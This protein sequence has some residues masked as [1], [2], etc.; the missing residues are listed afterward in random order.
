MARLQMRLLN[1][2]VGGYL[3]MVE[4]NLKRA[5]GGKR[6]K[7]IIFDKD[8]SLKTADEYEPISLGA[9]QYLFG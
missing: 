7:M 6:E 1:G 2:S 4:F 5:N 8:G 3:N 9:I